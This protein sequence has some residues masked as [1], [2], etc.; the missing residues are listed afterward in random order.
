MNMM[1]NNIL[2]K[3]IRIISLVLKSI[4]IISVSSII[5]LVLVLKVN[6]IKEG[7][8][9]H[10]KKYSIEEKKEKTLEYMKERYG[11][12]F[13]G[14]RWSG[15]N[16]FQSCD[17][18]VVY[19]KKKTPKDE[20]IVRWYYDDEKKVYDIY[21]NYM[22][23]LI[24]DKYT[25]YVTKLVRK[26]YPTAYINVEI[27]L[28][29]CYSNAFTQNT[30]INKISDVEIATEGWNLFCPHIKICVSDKELD[31]K[32]L[33]KF[34]KNMSDLFLNENLAVVL[35]LQV[36]RK[37]YFDEW[38][39]KK[40]DIYTENEDYEKTDQKYFLTTDEVYMSNNYEKN[41]YILCSDGEKVLTSSF[42]KEIQRKKNEGGQL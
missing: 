26:K 4:V 24:K 23:I 19:P 5:V 42:D 20:V 9:M 37:E 6:A 18:F 35:N 33:I 32:N 3:I 7:G 25:D 36:C 10:T 31:D 40:G 21:D 15:K 12:E 17:K 16:F 22:G 34:F 38:V 1:K 11:E 41:I 30:P 8:S 13:V 39:S 28:D 2:R 14:L 29:R 27:N